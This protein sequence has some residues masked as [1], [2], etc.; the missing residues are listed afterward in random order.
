VAR[1][2]EEIV[3]TK[4]AKAISKLVPYRE[5]KQTLSGVFAG[6]LIIPVDLLAPVVE[7]WGTD[8]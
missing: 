6:K 8:K 7:E 4:N 2:G 3:I 1:T 5:P